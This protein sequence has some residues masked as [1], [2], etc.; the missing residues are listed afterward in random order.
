M[1]ESIASVSVVI[2]MFNS[3]ATIERALDSVASQ[4][5]LPQELI[6][7]DDGSD[8]SSAKIVEQW[9]KSRIAVNLIK[10]SQNLGPS[11]SRNT[12]WDHA[13]Q[14]FVAFLD[15]DDAWHP[16]KLRIQTQL[17]QRDPKIALIG[18]QYDIGEDTQW[19]DLS[20]NDFKLSTFSLGDF[21]IRNRLSTPTV[22]VR[23]ELPNRF[24]S[25]QR[26]SED[27]R[28]WMEIVSECGSA[29]FINL[30]LTRLFKLTY[31]DSGLSSDLR[32][33][34]RGELHTYSDLSRKGVINRPIMI[35]CMTWSTI[36]Y[37]RRR[38]RLLTA[39]K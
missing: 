26:Y 36:K 30:P 7:I 37:C 14:K 15:A 3:A 24:A 21:L 2:P 38:M 31:G 13:T 6:V 34:Y 16:E 22:M 1:S 9:S 8:D 28:L 23:R 33:M 10:H 32:S 27:Y 18:H 4:S 39:N 20:T 35:M 29:S 19:K 25:D 17:M 12:G 11:A 5:L